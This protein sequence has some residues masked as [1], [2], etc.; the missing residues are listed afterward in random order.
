MLTMTP[1]QALK[2]AMIGDKS[3]MRGKLAS[4]GRTPKSRLFRWSVKI[5]SVALVLTVSRGMLR[6][7]EV[8]VMLAG[9]GDTLTQVVQDD[10]IASAHIA[11]TDFQVAASAFVAGLARP[12]LAVIS[13]DTADVPDAR[14]ERRGHRPSTP[15]ELSHIETVSASRVLSGPVEAVFAGNALQLAGMPVVIDALVCPALQSERGQLARV[16]LESFTHAQ[17]LNC[18]VT[19]QAGAQAVT[20]NCWTGDGQDLATQMRATQLCNAN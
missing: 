9:A 16:G 4:A 18:N 11:A 2:A 7:P 5:L 17:T 10:T 3:R 15:I 14:T 19:G 1:D 20:A 8:Q 13:H 12:A 6:A